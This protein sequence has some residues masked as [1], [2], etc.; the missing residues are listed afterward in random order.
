MP[1][2]PRYHRDLLEACLQLRP[3]SD[4]DRIAQE[5]ETNRA[6][7]ADPEILYYEGALLGYCGKKQAGI[8]LLQTA[9]ERNYCAYSNLVSDPLLSQL[10]SDPAINKV[11]TLSHECQDAVRASSS[12][13]TR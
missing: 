9:V 5:L 12:A 1:T 3:A 4:L 11:L 2:A 7:E 10:R 6:A 13:P 8:N